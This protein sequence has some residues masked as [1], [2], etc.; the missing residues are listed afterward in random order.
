MAIP[1]K[2]FRVYEIEPDDTPGKWLGQA[3][4]AAG[5]VQIMTAVWLTLQQVNPRAGLL[6]GLWDASLSSPGEIVA[7]V[8]NIAEREQP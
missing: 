6:I 1:Q 2:P 8:G 7:F 3:P 5:G 4:D